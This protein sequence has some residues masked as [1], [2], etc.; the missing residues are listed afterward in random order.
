VN[1][2]QRYLPTLAATAFLCLFSGLAA[3]ADDEYGIFELINQ[4]SGSFDETLV[5][6]RDA[7]GESGLT[8]HAEHDVRVPDKG[9]QAMSHQ[10][11]SPH[12]SCGL[13]FTPGVTTSEH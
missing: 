7:L 1:R 4:P 6:V 3:S 9:Q 8:V 12:R 11:Q 10:E 5:A 2:F 13:L